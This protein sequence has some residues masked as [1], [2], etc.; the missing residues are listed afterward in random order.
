MADVLYLLRNLSYHIGE[1]Y[2][3]CSCICTGSVLTFAG[4]LNS[5]KVIRH[6]KSIFEFIFLYTLYLVLE[7]PHYVTYM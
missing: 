1:I 4:T 6:N 7:I 5:E 2:E 3:T